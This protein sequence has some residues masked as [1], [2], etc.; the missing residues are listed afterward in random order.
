MESEKSDGRPVALVFG[1]AREAARRVAGVAVC[2]RLAQRLAEAGR[3]PVWLAWPGNGP[4]PRDA[5]DDLMRLANGGS[6]RFI[7]S[8]ALPA[9]TGE[10]GTRPLEVVR[11]PRLRA[12]DILKDTAKSSDGP[13]SRWL[14]R[15]VSRQISALLLQLPG[16]RPIHATAGTALI[17]AVMFAALLGG[18][19]AGLIAGGL[20]FHA[21]SVFD[22]VD[23]EIARATFRSSPAGA[24]A[25]SAVDIGT[26]LLFILGVTVNLALREVP[27]AAMVGAWGLVLFAIGL[28]ALA[29]RS[30][31]VGGPLDLD[32]LKESYRGRIQGRL[33]PL[34]KSFGTIVT[35]RDFFA[36]LFALLILA[37]WPMAVL[38]IFAGA[39][40]VW[41]PLV[42]A[43]AAPGRRERSA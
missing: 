23:G 39:A 41:I 40:T 11:A 31:R 43:T 20:L 2:A 13:I 7:D 12:G 5:M 15:P 14:N 24:A 6:V 19:G 32:I 38:Y 27:Q 17:A 22:G 37:G 18:G 4:L 25:D 29:R 36:L 8:D 21:A 42:L 35:S 26:N 33:A 1:S 30:G 10:A 16:I 9:L 34:L 28:L 3:D